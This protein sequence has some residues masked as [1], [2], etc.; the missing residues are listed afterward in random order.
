MWNKKA[1][2]ILWEYLITTQN[3]VVMGTPKAMVLGI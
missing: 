2:I 3:R 1:I